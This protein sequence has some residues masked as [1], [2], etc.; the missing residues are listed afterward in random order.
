VLVLI[1]EHNDC[2]DDDGGDAEDGAG[3][4]IIAVLIGRIEQ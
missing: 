2:I 1:I 3:I 4:D